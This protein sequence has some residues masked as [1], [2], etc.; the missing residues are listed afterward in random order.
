MY[1]MVAVFGAPNCSDVKRNMADPGVS[2]RYLVHLKSSSITSVKLI[3]NFW[4]L[5][6]LAIDETSNPE[7]ILQ[8]EH[9]FH[10]LLLQKVGEFTNS[11]EV[12]GN[13]FGISVITIEEKKPT[14]QQE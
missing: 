14:E 1:D 11:S 3:C 9:M 13:I 6:N 12:S 4:R 10:Q 2:P 8:S 7:R 5:E